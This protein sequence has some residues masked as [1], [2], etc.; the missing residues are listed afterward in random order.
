MMV[1]QDVLMGGVGCDGGG[2]GCDGGGAGCDGGRGR[3]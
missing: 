1:G 3:M 2:A